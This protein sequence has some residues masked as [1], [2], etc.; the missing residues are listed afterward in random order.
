[1]VRVSHRPGASG[2]ASITIIT[3]PTTRGRV[4]P[5]IHRIRLIL[6]TRNIR[7]IHKP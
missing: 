6:R 2:T 4:I 7:N 5:V 3:G 1:M